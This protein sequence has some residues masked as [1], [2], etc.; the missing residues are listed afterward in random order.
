[1]SS[2]YRPFNFWVQIKLIEMGKGLNVVDWTWTLD[3]VHNLGKVLFVNTFDDSQI[4]GNN[5]RTSR[6][7]TRQY[8]KHSSLG[9]RKVGRFIAHYIHLEFPQESPFSHEVSFFYPKQVPTQG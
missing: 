4:Q 6:V 5:N 1:M 8:N 2:L 9:F 3:N 7:W